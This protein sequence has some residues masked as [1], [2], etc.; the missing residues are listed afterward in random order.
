MAIDENTTDST[1]PLLDSTNPL[2]MHPSE[3]AGSMLVPVPF[4]GSGYRSWRRGV[5]RALLVKNKVGFINGKCTKPDP[6]ILTL[7]NGNAELEDR[8][9]QT[10]GVKLYQLQ[11]EINDLS[12][13]TLDIIGYYTKMKKLCE[14]LNT[15]NAHAQCKCNCTCGAKA[16]MQ[17]AEQDRRLIQ[18]LMGLN[19]VYTV[20]RGSILMMNPL[21]SLAQAFSILI[22]EEKQREVKPNSQFV[23]ESTALSANRSNAFR[24]NYNQQPNSADNTRYTN[25]NQQGNRIGNNNYRGGYSGSK[26]RPFCDYCKK[27][28]H[29]KERCYKFHGYP[30]DSRFN[31]GKR[32]VA[33]VHGGQSENS[34]EGQDGDSGQNFHAGNGENEMK[35]GA[36]NFAGISACSTSF[37]SGA[38]SNECFRSIADSWIL[39]SGASNHMT[40][41][42]FM[43][44]NIKTLL[45]PFLATLPNGYKVKV[46]LMGDVVMSPKFTLKK[47]PSLKR[48]LAIGKSK[49][50]LY[51][52]TSDSCKSNA[53]F[54]ASSS[55]KASAPSSPGLHLLTMSPDRPSPGLN[56]PN[57]YTTS[58]FEQYSPSLYVSLNALS[59]DSQ[60]L[61]KNISH[62]CEP[63]SYEEAAADPAW[64]K[65]MN[66]KF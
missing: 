65:A 9:D 19:E 15:L 8:Y 1:N 51:L 43:L 23:I 48:P 3:N 13:G 30:Q 36:V 49:D 32:I 27:P 4:D 14:E 62:E 55:N 64:Q 44:T 59:S 11:K 16:N 2:Y 57:S 52:Y 22:Q 46:T 42:K 6:R 39:D 10:N 50:G 12:Q 25:Y 54:H 66:Q 28:G 26:P 47:A 7:I 45:Y 37:D 31:K 33:N 21:P 61:I 5:L 56:E 34:M 38:N 60:K 41:K 58:D 40:Y 24:T 53:L 29:T 63:S 35:A 20:V 17:K 18:F